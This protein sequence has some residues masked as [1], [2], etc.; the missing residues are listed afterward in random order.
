MTLNHDSLQALVQQV[1]D[2]HAKDLGGENAHYIPYLAQVPSTL[3]ALLSCKAK[4]EPTQRVWPLTR[5]WLLNYMAANHN[6]R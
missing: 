3:S 5:L 4:S 1:Y 6:H 2:R